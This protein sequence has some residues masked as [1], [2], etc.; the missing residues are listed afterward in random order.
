MQCAACSAKIERTLRAAHGVSECSV[1]LITAEMEVVFDESELSSDSIIQK[2]KKL[3]YEAKRKVDSDRPFALETKRRESGALV[4][5]VIFTLLLFAVDFLQMIRLIRLPY[6]NE[7]NPTALAF[8]EL[9]LVL[10]VIILNARVIK[11]GLLALCRLSPNMHSLLALSSTAAFLYSLYTLV[12]IVKAAAEKRSIS[13]HLVHGLHF[14]SAA[15]ILTFVSIGE[16]LL[17]KTKRTTF[18]ALEEMAKLFPKKSLVI[19]DG[20]ETEVASK[21]ILMSDTVI[22]REGESAP[23][24]G[25]ISEGESDF[26]TSSITG[27]NLPVSKSAGDEVISGS[28]NLTGSVRIRPT[29][30]GENTTLAKILLLVK[31]AA[32]SKPASAALADRL[33]LYFIPAIIFIALLTFLLHLKTQGAS[34]AFSIAVSVLLVSCPCALGLAVPAAAAAAVGRAAQMGILIKDATVLEKF[35]H[36][37]TAVFD[38]TGT[39]TSGEL[40]ITAFVPSSSSLSENEAFR[41]AAS[42]EALSQHPVAKAVV[43]EAKKRSLSLIPTASFKTL[44]GK[45]VK[46]SLSRESKEAA[47]Y[48]G[49]LYIGNEK[50]LSSLSVSYPSEEKRKGETT[51]FLILSGKVGAVFFA[52]GKIK[53]SAHEA[54]SALR[55]ARIK[56][57]MLTGDNEESARK[58]AALLPLS[59]YA[60]SLLPEDKLNECLKIKKQN[61]GLLVFVGDGIND[62]PSLQAADVA[63]SLKGAAGIASESADVVLMRSSLTLLSDLRRLG[64]KTMRI[65]KENLFWAFFY[66]ALMLPVAAGVLIPFRIKMRPEIAAIAMSLSSLSVMLNA[67]RLKSFGKEKQKKPI[68]M[69]MKKENAMKSD[70]KKVSLKIEGMSCEHCRKTVERALDSLSGIKARVSLEEKRAD[71]ECPAS[72]DTNELVKCVKD[73]GYEASLDDK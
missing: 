67:L 13:P 39:L 60:S 65:I 57:Y 28:M 2:V 46:A 9:L 59:D 24:D 58:I 61:G 50:L 19:R 34:A 35:S 3:G 44:P 1:N 45:G 51:S 16:A 29:K 27:E 41:L 49:E 68:Q 5:S 32:S 7:G 42:I 64:V 43:R 30:T 23:V 66:N 37:K 62:A 31:R 71:V 53:K 52:S 12:L 70:T 10:P 14:D 17:S 6:I 38:K 72:L 20:K 4:L 18:R 63:V 33:A 54:L 15:M 22:L 26:D 36:V 69:E 21:E 8:A 48:E 47:K 56:T 55:E 73:A 25:V 11:D 40:E